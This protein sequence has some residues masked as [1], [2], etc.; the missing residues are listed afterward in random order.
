MKTKTFKS[1]SDCGHGWVAVKKSLLVELGISNSISSYSYQR[2]ATAYLEE[3]CDLTTF[4]KAFKAATGEVPV[5][6]EGKHQDRSPIR[7]YATYQAP[8]QKV[9][10]LFELA[11]FF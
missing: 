1:Y 9:T 4:V 11:A 3:D 10:P 8:Q 6:S 2:G 7:S 5:F